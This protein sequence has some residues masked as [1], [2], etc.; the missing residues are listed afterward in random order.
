MLLPSCSRHGSR[1]NA[2]DGPLNV[3]YATHACTRRQRNNPTRRASRLHLC[4]NWPRPC[5]IDGRGLDGAEAAKHGL[6][7]NTSPGIPHLHGPLR[8]LAN[9]FQGAST[10]NGSFGLGIKEHV[11]QRLLVRRIRVD[12]DVPLERAGKGSINFAVKPLLW[13]EVTAIPAL[14]CNP[15]L[16]FRDRPLVEHVRVTHDT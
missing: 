5:R 14:A 9:D 6:N 2:N 1:G 7:G 8:I 3:L 15:Q 13:L 10:K 12:E 16:L 4:P 11:K